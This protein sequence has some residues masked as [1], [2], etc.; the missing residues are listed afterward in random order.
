ME[1]E[2]RPQGASPIFSAGVSSQRRRW[3]V[4]SALGPERPNA[5]D[6]AIPV[7]AGHLD[8]AKKHVRAKLFDGL[9]SIL[10]G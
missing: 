4:A 7:F 10:R 3:R 2:T 8:V 6:Q 5:T 9:E 1:L